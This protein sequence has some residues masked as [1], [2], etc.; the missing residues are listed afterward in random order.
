LLIPPKK[1]DNKKMNIS[2]QL[3]SPYLG[4]LRLEFEQLGR[5]LDLRGEAPEVLPLKD[6]TRKKI[7]QIEDLSAS[8]AAGTI[9]HRGDQAGL[10]QLHFRKLKLDLRFVR[11][12]WL[13]VLSNEARSRKLRERKEDA[14][15]FAA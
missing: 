9:N 10:W 2:H 4:K 8:I 3:L 11:R 6:L 12:K 14:A 1:G 5:E 15:T 7:N 13:R